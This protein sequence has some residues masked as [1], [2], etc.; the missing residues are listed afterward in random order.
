MRWCQAQADGDCPFGVRHHIDDTVPPRDAPAA[1]PDDIDNAPEAPEVVTVPVWRT[2]PP[3]PLV[4]AA[5]ALSVKL[6]VVVCELVVVAVLSM[7]IW[8]TQTQS[9]LMCRA[10][11]AGLLWEYVA[12][13]P[14]MRALS[15]PCQT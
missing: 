15:F 6:P 12:H 9:P 7:I 5:P 11:Q 10:A 14:L 3:E 2:T 1:D 13:V 8:T 4:C